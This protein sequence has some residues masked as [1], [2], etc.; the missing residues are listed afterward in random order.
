MFFVT[1]RF[2]EEEQ[3]DYQQASTFLGIVQKVF[4]HC[5]PED[6]DHPPTAEDAVSMF[7]EQVCFQKYFPF[8]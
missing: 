2:C 3:Y 7:S 4:D 5:V 6:A 8:I 1:T